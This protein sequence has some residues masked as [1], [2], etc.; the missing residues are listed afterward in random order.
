MHKRTIAFFLST[1]LT[2]ASCGGAVPPAGTPHEPDV[3]AQITDRPRTPLGDASVDGKRFTI[4]APP[5]KFYGTSPT[6]SSGEDLGIGKRMTR[7]GRLDA[8]ASEVLRMAGAGHTLTASAVQKVLWFFGIPQTSVATTHLTGARVEGVIDELGAW[9]EGQAAEG[10]DHFGVAVSSG[11]SG[12]GGVAV[13]LAKLMELEPVE[14][15]LQQMGSVRLR[16]LLSDPYTHPALVVTSPSGQTRSTPQPL[17]KKGRFDARLELDEKGSWQIEVMADGPEGPGALVN[18]PLTVGVPI[19]RVVTMASGDLETKD[20]RGLEKILFEKLNEA[21]RQ[22]GLARLEWSESIGEVARGY[23]VEMARTGRIAHVSSISGTVSDRVR[24]A[25]LELLGVAENIAQ[26][27]NA[28]EAHEGLMASPGH[29]KNILSPDAASVGIGVVV[30]RQP[31]GAVIIVTQVFSLGQA[32]DLEQVGPPEILEIINA[33]RKTKGQKPLKMDEKLSR[34]GREA[35]RACF[36]REER[37]GEL[38]MGRYR[39]IVEVRLMTNDLRPAS[40][41]TSEE[42]TAPHVRDVGIAVARGRSPQ[43]GSSVLCIT[44]LLGER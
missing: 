1:A 22:N 12:A 44:L 18:F 24:A 2:L 31:L 21:R 30:A 17:N 6:E 7:D 40:F 8:V 26:A 10:D 38:D 20:P 41:A 11:E 23:S 43:T 27:G 3:E 33:A 14:S 9:L 32:A 29:R 28:A 15:Q 36:D 5:A 42:L 35:A 34:Q 13:S 37:K 39:S 25:G 16:G 4:D 19:N